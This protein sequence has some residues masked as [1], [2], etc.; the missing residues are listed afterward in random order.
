[1]AHCL[2]AIVSFSFSPLIKLRGGFKKKSI[3][4]RRPPTNE[5]S[6]WFLA[7]A[8]AEAICYL[9]TQYRHLK[10]PLQR[11]IHSIGVSTAYAGGVIVYIACI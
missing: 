11:Y 3:K 1:M 4:L 8:T 6:C 9:E 5:S 10:A 7:L 2:A